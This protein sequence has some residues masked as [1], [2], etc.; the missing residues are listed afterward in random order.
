MDL[1]RE[2]TK[3]L[4]SSAEGNQ[5]QHLLGS[6]KVEKDDYCRY[7]QQL[8]VLHKTLGELLQER[9][10]HPA[11]HKIVQDYHFDLTCLKNDLGFF[12]Q[13]A[14]ASQAVPATSELTSAMS[15]TAAHSPAGLL[16]Y[17]YVLEGSTNGAKFLAKAL[18]AGLNLPETAGA[19]YFDRYGDKQ[20]E[21][22]MK[23]KEDM[24]ELEFSD[25]ERAELVANAK[26]TFHT[27]S[28]IGNQLLNK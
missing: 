2:S 15:R 4:H 25:E 16:G 9:K 13:T 10:A 21:R 17:L 7:L 12:N 5:F 20:R 19:S 26:E 18:R 1:L 28:K 24:N 27:F 23:F 3:D 22:W 14:E 8:Y 11:L 6:G